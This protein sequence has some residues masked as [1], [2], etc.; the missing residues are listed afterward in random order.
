MRD[1]S[2]NLFPTPC[3]LPL[4]VDGFLAL[5]PVAGTKLVG[6]QCVEHAQNLLRIAAHREIGDIHKA[7]H[8]LR[9]DDERCALANAGLSVQNAELLREVALEVREHGIR[10]I[11][12]V[13][14]IIAPR[15]VNVLGIDAG[16]E[17][18]R[19]AVREILIRLA[20][21]GDLSG[22]YEREIL[23]P[24]KVDLPLAGIALIGDG[25]EGVLDVGADDA[26]KFESG[27]LLSNSEHE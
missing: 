9:I 15:K 3:S 24:E 27:E 13:R 10:Q 11:L 21:G 18:L 17:N 6:L 26:G 12:Q 25:L 19:I 14:M 23:R 4:N 8:A 22:A 20:K 2:A 16:A 7:D 1:N 5:L